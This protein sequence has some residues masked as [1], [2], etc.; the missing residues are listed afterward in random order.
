MN[1]SLNQTLEI[2]EGLA[3]K[4]IILNMNGE[5]DSD[6]QKAIVGIIRGSEFAFEELTGVKYNSGH[7]T[8]RDSEDTIPN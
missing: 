6:L 2:L 7:G 3:H 1:T 4:S 5:H 8:Y